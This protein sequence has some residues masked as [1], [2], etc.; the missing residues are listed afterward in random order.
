MDK[1][2][3]LSA[4]I[5]S[6][7]KIADGSARNGSGRTWVATLDLGDGIDRDLLLAET[8]LSIGDESRDEN[9]LGDHDCG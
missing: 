3:Y 4:S 6:T 5:G 1:M 9:G 7:Q 8:G 2:T